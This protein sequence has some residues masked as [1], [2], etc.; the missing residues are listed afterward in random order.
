MSHSPHRVAIVVD[1]TFGEQLHALA[2]GIHV[3]IADTPANRPV[4]ER[5][6]AADPPTGTP[7]DLEYGVTTFNVDAAQSPEQWCAAIVGTVEEHHGEV[8]HRPAVSELEVYGTPLTVLLQTA[9]A[10]YGFEKFEP[11][12]DGFRARL[13]PAS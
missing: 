4:A 7:H 9:F 10:A 2:A 5:F 1:P 11:T 3:W 12:S 8:G 6:W 13:R